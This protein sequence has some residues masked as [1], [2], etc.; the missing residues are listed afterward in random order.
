MQILY[1]NTTG[2]MVLASLIEYTGLVFVPLKGTLY[3]YEATR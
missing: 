1:L 2:G 3:A